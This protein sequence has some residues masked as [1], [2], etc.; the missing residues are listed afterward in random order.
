MKRKLTIVILFLLCTFS[1]AQKSFQKLNQLYDNA[2]L[3]SDYSSTFSVDEKTNI[4]LEDFKKWVN[5]NPNKFNDLK[6]LEVAY[7][8]KWYWGSYKIVLAKIGFIKPENVNNRIAYFEEI[9][10]RNE[11]EYRLKR[12]AGILTGALITGGLIY[13]GKKAYDWWKSTPTS[14]YSGNYSS[15]NNSKQENIN[16]ENECENKLT[17]EE[18]INFKNKVKIGNWVEHL[19][20]NGSYSWVELSSGGITDTSGRKVTRYKSNS[21]FEYTGKVGWSEYTFNSMDDYLYAVYVMSE[22]GK[23]TNKVSYKK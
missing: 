14:D 18:F 9:R 19:T 21:G 3:N 5:A 12:E 23:L 4:L 22:C 20:D 11:E 1:F 6:E 16:S 10:K 17:N 15:S 13:A 2:Q 8:P 7:Q